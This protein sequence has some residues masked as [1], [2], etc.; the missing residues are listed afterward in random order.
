MHECVK[1]ET[2]WRIWDM[3]GNGRARS[4]W[5]Y[6]FKKMDAIVFVVDASD[7]TRLKF[8]KAEFFRVIDILESLR[9]Y[10]VILVFLNKDDI[11]EINE[12]TGQMQRINCETFRQLFQLDYLQGR[13]TTRLQ[14]CSG[15][16]GT[17]I[18]EGLEWIIGKTR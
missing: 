13:Y 16:L 9:A 8:A 5:K 14:S 6:Y 1:F 15:L 4:M 7:L 2:S 3:S 17:G 18:D 12:S 11:P 10:P